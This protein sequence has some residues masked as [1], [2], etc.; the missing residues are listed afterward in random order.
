[1]MR[2][3]WLDEVFLINAAADLTALA[4]AGRL[5]RAGIR[6]ARLALG[7]L[8]GALYACA[9][10][11]YGGA[12]ASL[13]VK[14]AAGGL[15]A[16]TVYGGEARLLRVTAAF[17]AV[18][19]AMAGLALGTSAALGESGSLSPRALAVTEGL[20]LAGLAAALRLSSRPSGGLHELELEYGGKSVRLTALADTGNAL[21]DPLSGEPT[22]VVEALRAAELL[23]AE[24]ASALTAS[25]SESMR[26]LY[27][28]APE[29][30]CRL[31]PYRAVG[32]ASGLLLAVRL[33]GVSVDGKRLRSG[34]VALSPTKLS[35][36]GEY[37]ALVG[38]ERI[39]EKGEK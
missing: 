13:P 2:E 10:E 9:A 11:V 34:W 23:P 12:L 14:L 36:S 31:V 26:R 28:A 20:T 5:C 35:E 6:P 15:M 39:F 32:V 30:R 37:A 33:D 18:A 3:V 17:F 29:L 21:R 22:P 27:A 25:A 16:L 4:G 7:V 24:A 8:L 19:A 38:G 1:M